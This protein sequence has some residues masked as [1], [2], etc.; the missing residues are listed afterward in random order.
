MRRKGP[1]FD[2]MDDTAKYIRA[3]GIGSRYAGAKR[4]DI[5]RVCSFTVDRPWAK[6]G[7]VLQVSVSQQKNLIDSI[8][9][10][11]AMTTLSTLIG[12]GSYPTDR[13]GMMFASLVCRRATELGLRAKVIN[14]WE[15]PSK[16]TLKIPDVVIMHNVK[17]DSHPMRLQACRDWLTILDDVFIVVIVSGTDPVTFFQNKLNH[18]LDAAIYFHGEEGGRPKNHLRSV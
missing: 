4:D 8:L 13:M 17:S 15:N 2:A 10:G 14:L 9:D 7:T 12:V 3:L 1:L 5:G 11:G 6:N 16:N 18:P